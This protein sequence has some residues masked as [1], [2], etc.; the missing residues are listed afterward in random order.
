MDNKLKNITKVRSVKDISN[1]LLLNASFIDNLGLMHG[2]MGISIWAYSIIKII[3]SLSFGYL[4]SCSADKSHEIPIINPGNIAFKKISVSEIAREITYIPLNNNFLFG[5]IVSVELTD[6]LIFITPA[7]GTLFVYDYNGHFIRRIGKQGRGPGEY[8]YANKFTLDRKNKTV[9]ILSDQRLLK[10]SFNGDFLETIELK[11]DIKI[12]SRIVYTNGK[13]VLFEG[14]NQGEGKYD[15]VVLDI[16]GNILFEKFNAIENFP[17][18]HYCCGNKQEAF[19]NTFYYWNQINDTI[20]KISD[21]KYEPA[22]IFTQGN[23][24]FPKQKIKEIY[25]EYFFPRIVFFTK[26]YL[27]FAYIY[28]Y[29][30]YTGIYVKSENQFYYVNVTEDWNFIKGPGIVNDFDSGVPLIPLSY[31]RDKQDKEYLIGEV[32][33]F[34]L[35]AHVASDVFKNSTPH[36]PEKKKELEKLANSLNEND[37]PVLMLVKLKD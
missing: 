14:I 21:E 12:F 9:Y 28:Q 17:S 13:L 20:F 26:D 35:K 25:C 37:N 8:T 29:Q 15:W 16:F 5:S 10:Y 1:T 32:N 3:I 30:N 11:I 34:Q 7:L 22:F 18:D 4:I 6:S 19:N 27:F 33:P 23:F 31:Y 24:R 2:K 36:Y